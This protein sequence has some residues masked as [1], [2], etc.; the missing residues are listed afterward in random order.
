[1][2]WIS[3]R[4]MR[5]GGS[6]GRGGLKPCKKGA[7]LRKIV[8]TVVPA[9]SMFSPARVS[10]EC[11]HEAESWGGVRARCVACK[12]GRRMEGWAG[13]PGNWRTSEYRSWAAMK[14]R[15]CNPKSIRYMYYGARGIRVCERWLGEGGFDRFIEDMGPKPS[16]DHSIDRIDNNGN[17][18]PGNCRWATRLQQARNNRNAALTPETVREIRIKHAAGA[19]IRPLAREYG[20]TQRTISDCVRFIT[21]KDVA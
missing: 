5:Q 13:A 9:A 17:Y 11:G 1:M 2:G 12:D 19:K 10:L 6:I 3:D 7:P 20:V 18:E 16:R 21:W 4:H 8:A 15:C 14:A